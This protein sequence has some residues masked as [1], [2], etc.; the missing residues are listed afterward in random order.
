MAALWQILDAI[1]KKRL[2]NPED[3]LL[4]QIAAE[5]TTPVVTAPTLLN[6]WV[7]FGSSFANAGYY[8]DTLG[9]VHLR[10]V[11]KDGTT[12]P[13]TAFFTLPAGYR[14]SAEL[15]FTTFTFDG[16]TQSACRI[17]VHANGNVATGAGVQSGYLSLD[18]VSFLAEQ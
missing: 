5:A 3:A 8:K 7:N 17:D 4:A 13:G 18:S 15:L 2:A 11:L 16:V 14:P 10:G 12:T 1:A 9:R 6:S